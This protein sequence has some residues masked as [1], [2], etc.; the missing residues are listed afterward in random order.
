MLSFISLP[1]NFPMTKVTKCPY[2]VYSWADRANFHYVFQC[3]SSRISQW[4]NLLFN[5]LK[6]CFS[7]S[8]VTKSLQGYSR[9]MPLLYGVD[10]L[11]RYSS[12]MGFLMYTIKRFIGKNEYQTQNVLQ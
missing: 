7:N 1:R 3:S 4:Y 11:K 8:Y 6:I 9:K 12:C 5:V 2:N 10:I